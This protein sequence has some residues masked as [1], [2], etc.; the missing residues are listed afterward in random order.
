MREIQEERDKFEI[1]M[2]NHKAMSMNIEN[3]QEG[4]QR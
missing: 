1:E 4:L 3:N 2:N